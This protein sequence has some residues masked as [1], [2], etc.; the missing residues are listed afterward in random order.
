AA[1]EPRAGSYQYRE[2]TRRQR[3][4]RSGVADLGPAGKE[5][6]QDRNDIV[7][8]PVPG[9]VDQQ[10]AAAGRGG[11]VHYCPRSFS[12]LW[13]SSSMREAF[14]GVS[15]YS[16]LRFGTVRIATFFFISSRM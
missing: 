6:T 10:H 16:N 5:L 4:E 9:L 1:L 13:I 3:I 15:S 11:I 8:G 14:F 12:S 7:G 2:Q